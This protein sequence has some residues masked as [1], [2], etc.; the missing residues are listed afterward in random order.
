[1]SVDVE[2]P[3]PFRKERKFRSYTDDEA[4]SS[5]AIGSNNWFKNLKTG[6]EN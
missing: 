2:G 6:M 3:F 4:D 1:M 5:R